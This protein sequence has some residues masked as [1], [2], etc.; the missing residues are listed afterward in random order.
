MLVEFMDEY[1]LDDLTPLVATRSCD[2]SERAM[3]ER[4]RSIPDGVYRNAIQIEGARRSRSRSP[5]PSTS[6]RREV[7]IDFAGTSPAVAG[8]HQ[9]A[10]LLH[11]RLRRVRDQVPDHARRFP[12]NE[13]ACG[14][15]SSPR[16]QGCMLNA[17]PPSP[18]GGRHIDRAFRRPA[19]LRRAGGGPARIACRPTP[20]C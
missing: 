19:D 7:A 15:S 14:R 13:G 1:G 5:A 20:A 9:R 4:D 3:R 18:T 2:Q 11:A 6:R 16:R 12:N 17:L 10:A 8:G